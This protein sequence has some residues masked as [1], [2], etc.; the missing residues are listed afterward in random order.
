MTNAKPSPD[1]DVLSA[2]R[3]D[4]PTIWIHWLTLALICILFV[5]AWLRDP[6]AS[7][8]QAAALLVVHRSSG[9]LI[10]MLTVMRMAW[11][12]LRGYRPALPAGMGNLQRFAAHANEYALYGLLA[13][14]PLTGLAQSLF[15]A[16]PFA[17]FFGTVPALFARNRPLTH[18]ARDF[19][20]YGAWALLGLIAIHALAALHHHF[21]KHDA[22]LKSMLPWPAK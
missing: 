21:V 11:R 15:P 18:F 16:K 5:T 9:V 12:W 17:L 1:H 19:H 13:L 6:E 7:A 2:E 20:E 10:W 3:F 22:V 8:P 4:A 14:Q